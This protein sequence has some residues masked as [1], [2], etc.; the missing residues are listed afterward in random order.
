[1]EAEPGKDTLTWKMSLALEASEL[2]AARIDALDFGVREMP[3]EFSGDRF[4]DL[5]GDGRVRLVE[6]WSTGQD[7]NP[8]SMLVQLARRSRL[9]R[10]LRPLLQ[11][12]A[13]RKEQGRPDCLARSVGPHLAH[14][15]LEARTVRSR[16]PHVCS[17]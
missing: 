9:R 3:N 2:D 8:C 16:L 4:S 13:P 15:I 17:R 7:V 5:C 11:R 14:S 12:I 10:S 6:A 1:M